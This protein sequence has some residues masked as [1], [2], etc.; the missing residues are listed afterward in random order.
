MPAVQFRGAPHRTEETGVVDSSP[1]GE[2]ICRAPGTAL[3]SSALVPPTLAAQFAPSSW[4]HGWNFTVDQVGKAPAWVFMSGS[5]G[6]KGE[7]GASQLGTTYQ[8]LSFAAQVHREENGF[9][10]IRYYR[11]YANFG[12]AHCWLE[13]KIKAASTSAREPLCASRRRLGATL[14]EGNWSA[15]VSLVQA[16]IF[17]SLRRG[18]YT[19]CISPLMGCPKFKVAAVLAC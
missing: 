11:S 7:V 6:Q 2:L 10:S 15:R 5:E 4:G 1:F 13:P 17:R 9:I 3:G 14:L 19:V 8:V 18:E 12:G 16:H